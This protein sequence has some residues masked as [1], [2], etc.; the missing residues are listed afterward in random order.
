M[1]GS[2]RAVFA[3][4]SVSFEEQFYLLWPA[5]IAKARGKGLLWACGILLAVATVSRVMSRPVSGG[6]IE[7]GG[8]AL[9]SDAAIGG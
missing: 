6:M 9:K 7:L 1:A 5:V 2:L 8:K 4:W 3:L